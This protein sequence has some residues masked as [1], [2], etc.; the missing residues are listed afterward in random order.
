MHGV[1]CGGNIGAAPY[2]PPVVI[3]PTA[4]QQA[5][6]TIA[7]IQAKF[8][9]AQIIAG[10]RNVGADGAGMWQRTRRLRR[11]LREGMQHE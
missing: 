6:A 10:Q 11:F 1:A 9:N 4:V 2:V 8:I 5:Q 3:P 7:A